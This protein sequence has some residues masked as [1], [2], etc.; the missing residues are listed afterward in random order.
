MLVLK[1]KVEESIT[2]SD[3][4]KIKILSI[5]GESVNVGVDAPRELK[6]F[7]TE[8]VKDLDNGNS[9]GN[10]SRHN[11]RKKGNGTTN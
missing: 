7:R 9:N 10:G 11:G 3:N 1:R 2:I 4:I 5:N 6:V 8:N